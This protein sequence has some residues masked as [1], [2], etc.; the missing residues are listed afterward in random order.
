[1][2]ELSNLPDIGKEVERQLKEFYMLH[3]ILRE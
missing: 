2:G 1:M 3:R